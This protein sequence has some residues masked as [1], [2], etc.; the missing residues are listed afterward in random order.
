VTYPLCTI[1][2]KPRLPE[3]CIEYVR[4]LLWTKEKP[5]DGMHKSSGSML[6]WY[7]HWY[8]Y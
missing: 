3:H 4:I 7:W 8:Q 1:A 5:F 6:T 2:S